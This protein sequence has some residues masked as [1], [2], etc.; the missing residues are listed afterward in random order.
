MLFKVSALRLLAAS[1]PAHSPGLIAPVIRV[2]EA[3]SRLP[4]SLTLSCGAQAVI[5]LFQGIRYSNRIQNSNRSTCLQCI[6]CRSCTENAHLYTDGKH[7]R[8]EPHTGSCL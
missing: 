2:R 8:V 5:A 6:L 1:L 3:R 7:L 4:L